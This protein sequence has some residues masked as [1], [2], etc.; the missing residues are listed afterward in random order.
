[1]ISDV[2]FEQTPERLK[3]VMPLRR[4][5]LFLIPYS[6]LAFSWMV[7]VVWGLVY[8]V[9]ILFSRQSYRFVFA[10]MIIVLLLILL[11]FGKFLMR[12]WAHYLSNREIVFINR[13]ELIVRR[14]VSIWGNTDAYDMAHVTHFYQADKPLALA[15]DYGYRHIYVGEALTAAGRH[16]LL[17]YL[18]Q[19]YFPGYD[20]DED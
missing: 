7:M 16:A 10:L 20:E 4:K 1:M 6:I 14:P 13:E 15:F 5:W 19:T 3:I 18:N 11:S 9:Q 2:H 17:Q 8:L 12:Q